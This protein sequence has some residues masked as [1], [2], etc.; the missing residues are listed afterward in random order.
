MVGEKKGNGGGE[1]VRIG[2]EAS[3]RWWE[4]GSKFAEES[5]GGER[6]SFLVTAEPS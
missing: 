6:V 2:T 3:P 4:V 1:T 5:G